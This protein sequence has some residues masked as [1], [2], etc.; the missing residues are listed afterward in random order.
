MTETPGSYAGEIIPQS[1][2]R[3]TRTE[4]LEFLLWHPLFT[5]K[6][7]QCS[8]AIAP[9]DVSF[10]QWHCQFCRSDGSRVPE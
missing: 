9:V 2:H 10:Y 8:E 7:P 6:C 5:G 4:Q 1:S 3:L